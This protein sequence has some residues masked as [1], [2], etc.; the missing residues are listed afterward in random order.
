MSALWLMAKILNYW[1]SMAWPVKMANVNENGSEVAK[2]VKKMANLTMKM[3]L[4]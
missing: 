4:Y 1:N 3:W 2:Y